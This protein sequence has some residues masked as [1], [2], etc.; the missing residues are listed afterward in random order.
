MVADP[1]VRSRRRCGAAGSGT[2]RSWARLDPWTLQ[3]REQ[4]V[5]HRGSTSS[6]NQTR[7]F[8]RKSLR[9]QRA[10]GTDVGDVHRIGIVEL[11]VS[12]KVSSTERSPRPKTPSS[13]G[14]RDLVGRSA[15]SGDT[16]CS[17]PGRTRWWDRGRR[18][19]WPP[20]AAHVV[21]ALLDAVVEG[22]VLQ[23]ALARPGRR[24]GSRAG[25]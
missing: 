19:S 12:G 11:C 2:P 5:A 7:I 16:G 22:V 3:P 14:L 13:R 21:R 6:R 4:L 8:R 20:A 1:G 18:A 15:R 23:L 17:A 10:D 24:S 9:G 25:G